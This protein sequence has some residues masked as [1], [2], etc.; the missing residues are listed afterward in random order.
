M[1]VF[2]TDPAAII[3]RFL[4]TTALLFF[5]MAAAVAA[6]KARRGPIHPPG[7]RR[8]LCPGHGRILPGTASQRAGR[9]EKGG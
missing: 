5:L 2:R 1:K 3:P 6:E 4:L 8:G 9:A 7:S